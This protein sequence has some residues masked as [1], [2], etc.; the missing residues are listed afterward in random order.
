MSLDILNLAKS[1]KL[2]NIIVVASTIVPREDVYKKKADEVSSNLEKLCKVNYISQK[3]QPEKTFNRDRLQ[4]ND[5]GESVLAGND[6][7]FLNNFD[8]I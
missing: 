8:E 3:C 6:R 5:S 2:N 4:F 7:D 1:L